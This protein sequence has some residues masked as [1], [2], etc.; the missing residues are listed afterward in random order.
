MTSISTTLCN[1]VVFF[2]TF[3]R[4]IS[5]DMVRACVRAW[6]FEVARLLLQRQAPIF[7]FTPFRV[8]FSGPARMRTPY[9]DVNTKQT[10][11]KTELERLVAALSR[12]HQQVSSE[13]PQEE[14]HRSAGPAAP[15][16]P[17]SNA[18]HGGGR[19]PQQR[20]H[21]G[22]AR[23]SKRKRLQEV[24][25]TAAAAVARTTVGGAKEQ[26]GVID[27]LVLFCW[28]WRSVAQGALSWRDPVTSF[29]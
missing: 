19:A 5:C 9:G 6:L 27:R 7:A 2:K 26:A 8:L 11:K 24:R 16:A 18:G 13:E 12:F 17:E 1:I 15:V 3:R 23:L 25:R 10:T 21:D 20:E 28:A 29:S 14:D 4:E 22:D